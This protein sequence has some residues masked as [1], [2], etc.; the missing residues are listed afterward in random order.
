MATVV[1]L[2]RILEAELRAKLE[3][4]VRLR[5]DPYPLDV[6]GRGGRIR[7][8]GERRRDCRA[9]PDRVRPASRELRTGGKRGTFPVEIPGETWGLPVQIPRASDW[10]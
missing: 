8:D 1:P 9:G 4:D 5:F 7:Q 6:Q 3:A 10:Q 2:A